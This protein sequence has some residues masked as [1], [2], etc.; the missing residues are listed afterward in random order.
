MCRPTKEEFRADCKEGRLIPIFREIPA[1]LETPVSAFLKLRGKGIGFLLESVERGEQLGRYSILGIDPSPIL[2]RENGITEIREGGAG[3][4]AEEPDPLRTLESLMAAYRTVSLPGLPPF[5]GG[6]VGYI[7]YE[8]AH[9]FERLPGKI[10]H[11]LNL[12][13]AI[14]LL[15]D[16]LVIF[17]HVTQKLMVMVNARGSSSPDNTYDQAVQRISQIVESLGKPLRNGRTGRGR[18]QGSLRSSSEE[19]TFRSNFTPRSFSQAVGSA[20]EYIAKGD[21]YQIVFSQRLKGITSA[22]PFTIYRALRML[23]PSPYMFFLDFSNFQLIGSSPE[24]LVKTT[25]DLAE[26]RPIA[27]TR[28]RGRTEAEDLWLEKELIADPKERAEHVMLLD[29]GRN[30]LGRVCKFGSVQAPALMEVERYSHVMHMVSRAQGLLREGCSPY[31]LLRAAFPAGTVT[32]AP[33]IRAME[34]VEELEKTE[35]GPYAGAVV[36]FGLNGSLNSCITIR[37]IVMK[38]RTVYLQAGAGIVADSDP[39]REYEE[40]VNKIQALKRAILTAEE[41]W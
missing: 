17:D 2:W 6:V 40:T 3:R 39:T 37:T 15:A 4:T 13:E 30:D 28:K 22:D 12:P 20:K 19:R 36:T 5:F 7:S 21:A 25:G 38:G 26:T 41:G 11:D 33:K 35:R 14:F 18:T 29:L 23:N 32:G 8:V 10:K 16:K 27:G 34:I 1:D 31:D 24:M 9:C